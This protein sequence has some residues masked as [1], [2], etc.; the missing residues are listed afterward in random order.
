MEEEDEDAEDVDAEDSRLAGSVRVWWWKVEAEAEA[1]S[2]EEKGVCI[3]K[4]MVDNWTGGQGWSCTVPWVSSQRAEARTSLSHVRLPTMV[5][6][7]RDKRRAGA[8][9]VGPMG[10]IYGLALWKKPETKNNFA[11]NNA[12]TDRYAEV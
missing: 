4:S 12:D 3:W 11:T 6:L 1:V 10:A 7:A 8:G 2:E 5:A 9:S